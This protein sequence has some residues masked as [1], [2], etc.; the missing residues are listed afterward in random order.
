MVRRHERLARARDLHAG[1][2]DLPL[3]VDVIQMEQRQQ[4]RIG[5]T[6]L[7]VR[8]EVDRLEL[9]GELSGRQAAA[10]LVD[11]SQQNLRP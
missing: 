5:T 11:V 7:Q 9:S 3:V 8:A 4:A 2:L 10:P 6:A 1:D